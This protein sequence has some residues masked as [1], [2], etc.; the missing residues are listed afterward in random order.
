MYAVFINKKL[1]NTRISVSSIISVE[2]RSTFHPPHMKN[3]D[4]L[5]V[6]V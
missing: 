5:F 6:F 2:M 4:L 3:S 1:V